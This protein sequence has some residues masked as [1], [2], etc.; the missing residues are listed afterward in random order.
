MAIRVLTIDLNGSQCVM[1]GQC[2]N[3]RLW[4][5]D[6]YSLAFIF[7]FVC[8]SAFSC[9]VNLIFCFVVVFFFFGILVFW[10]FV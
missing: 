2:F 9:A 5:L 8:S 7:F 6:S 10:F 1:V 3:L 4:S